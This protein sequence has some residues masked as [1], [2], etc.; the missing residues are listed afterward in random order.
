M[1]AGGE[2]LTF[3]Q[4]AL[5]R[6]TGK[7]CVLLR[8]RK[9]QREAVKHFGP[10]PGERRVRGDVALL[11][12]AGALPGVALHS[13]LGARAGR[14]GRAF[15]SGVCGAAGPL[16]GTLLGDVTFEQGATWPGLGG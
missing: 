10:A 2:C 11:G 8:G 4:L 15:G 3:D 9:S 1:Q 7:D 13:E 14:A 12:A 16:I 5:Q 6:P